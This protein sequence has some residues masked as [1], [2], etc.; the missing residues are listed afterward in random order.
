[1]SSKNTQ[2]KR[3]SGKIRESLAAQFRT[4]IEIDAAAATHNYR[5]IRKAID[6]DVQLWSVIK[7]N[8]Y[9]HGLLTFPHILAKAGIDGFCVDSVTEAF[10][11]RRDGIT[12]FILVLGHTLSIHYKEAVRQNITLTISTFESLA[13]LAKQKSK[14]MI[15][16]IHLKIDTGMHRQGFYPTD[17]Q[18]V[19]K[20]IKTS[21]I[22]SA[23][24][25]GAYTHFAAAKNAANT[26][27]VEQQY[28]EFQNVKHA[29]EKVGFANLVFHAAASGGMMLGKPYHMDAVRVGMALC[30]IFP[31]KELKIQRPEFQLKPVLSW[32]TI[33]SEVK[34]IKKGEYV[35][36]DFAEQM[37]HAGTLAML[38]VGYWHGFKRSLSHIGEVLIHGKRAKVVGRVSMDMLIVDIT[39]I[40]QVHPGTMATIIGKDGKD[41]ITAEEIA[42]KMGTTWYEALT[43][44]NPLIERVQV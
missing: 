30:G 19:I 1:M 14:A 21:K 32:R 28:A 8:A 7:S 43:T 16:N 26:K 29:L 25:T 44:L 2:G 15:P 40:R 6:A 33:V 22:L 13:L 24:I 3:S 20:R 38:P 17:M 9:G 12:Q 27:Y 4:W 10:R 35:G 18:K 23:R 34:P 42:L 5:T 39:G 37:L 36:Y 41:E 31:S 11:L